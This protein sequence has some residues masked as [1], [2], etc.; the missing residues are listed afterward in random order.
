M[1]KAL[2]IYNSK[3]GVTKNYGEEINEFLRKK[4][5]D[6]KVVSISECNTDE[7]AE[8]D[9]VLFGCWTSGLFLFKQGPEQ[10]WIDFVKNVPDLNN[11]KVGLFTTY[12][13]ATGGMFKKMKKYL[14]VNPEENI[15]E[16]KSKDGHLPVSSRIMINDFVRAW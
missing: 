9:M 12:K 6:S 10:E 8:Y 2:D 7:I 15:L 14:R 16:L 3:N 4:D 13:V 5:I 11:K 1:K